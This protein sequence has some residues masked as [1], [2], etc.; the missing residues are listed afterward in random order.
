MRSESRFF[1]HLSAN[2]AAGPRRPARQAGLTLVELLVAISVMAFVAV[3][4]WRGLDTIL[5]ARVSLT[6]ELEQTRGMQLAFAQLQNDCAQ[7]ASA[8]LLGNRQPLRIDQGRLALIRTV[9]TE[10]QP[11]RVQ[12][13]S[14]QVVDGV[15]TRREL[16]PTRNL[17]ELDSQ[18]QSVAAGS[19]AGYSVALQP[20]VASVALRLWAEDNRGWRTVDTSDGNEAAQGS[21]K[22]Q[23]IAQSTGAPVVRTAYTGLELTLRLAGRDSA[24]QKI[25]L[26][27][28]V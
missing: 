10:A 8:S 9:Q 21:G 27:G 12:V 15:L 4:G 24:M 17:G 26:L 5:R 7:I 25:F 1:L 23:I 16:P 11:L 3:M 18:M 20:G 19:A 22:A 13:V 6:S 14:W 28:A 2:R